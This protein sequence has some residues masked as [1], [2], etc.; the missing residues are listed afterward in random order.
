MLILGMIASVL[1]NVSVVKK[2]RGLEW[3]QDVFEAVDSGA[4]EGLRQCLILGQDPDCV[5]QQSALICAINQGIAMA[6]WC[7]FR[8]HPS[9]TVASSVTYCKLQPLLDAECNPNSPDLEGT[10]LLHHALSEDYRSG[11]CRAELVSILLCFGANVTWNFSFWVRSI[12][13]NQ[14]FMTGNKGLP[15]LMSRRAK[16]LWRRLLDKCCKISIKTKAGI[17]QPSLTLW[18]WY[19]RFLFTPNPRAWHLVGINQ[20]LHLDKEID[21]R[22][23]CSW[24]LLVCWLQSPPSLL[25]IKARHLQGNYWN[26]SWMRTNFEKLNSIVFY[27]LQKLWFPLRT[28]HVSPLSWQQDFRGTASN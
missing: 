5:L 19:C 13:R 2:P 10:Y 24:H 21:E 22:H 6:G 7:V 4:E 17:S 14:S 9:R 12:T 18:F 20:S 28:W 15:K 11:Q 1:T 16:I 26:I 3:T 27:I 25:G 8:L 23:V